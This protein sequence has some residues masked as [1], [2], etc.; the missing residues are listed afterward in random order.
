MLGAQMVA[1]HCLAMEMSRRALTAEYRDTLID[2][3]GFANKFMRTYAALVEALTRYRGKG[4][5]KVVVEHVHVHQGA[6]AIIGA[7]TAGGG[8]GSK[9][10]E[11]ARALRLPT[12]ERR[13]RDEERDGLERR[14]R[15]TIPACPPKEGARGLPRAAAD[16]LPEVA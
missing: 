12:G 9:I 13:L 15:H 2:A 7:V 11:Q 3:A 14:Q 10:E 5:Q 6:Q 1:S 4:E 8:G 16:A